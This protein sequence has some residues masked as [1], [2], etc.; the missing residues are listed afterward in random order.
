MAISMGIFGS[1]KVQLF[2]NDFHF[3]FSNILQVPG[4][5]DVI[6]DIL[7]ASYNAALFNNICIAQFLHPFGP[8]VE[9]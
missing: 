6:S 1:E 2:E 7:S 5:D 3:H 9:L 4:N 8:T